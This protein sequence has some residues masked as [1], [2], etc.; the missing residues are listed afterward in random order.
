MIL[1]SQR[2]MAL[3]TGFLLST[4][5]G[6]TQSA[7][8]L[9]PSNT[10]ADTSSI[11]Q[12]DTPQTA[13]PEA[14]ANAEKQI[15]SD[16]AST[17]LTPGRY[18]YQLEDET[19]TANIRLTLASDNQIT[20]DTQATIHN[21]EA[22][23][24]TSYLQK[25][26][27]TQT[28]PQTQ[29]NITTWIEYDVQESTETWTVGADTLETER[30]TLTT[31]D[32]AVVSQGFQDESGLE[33]SDLLSDV[34]LHTQSVQFEPGASSATFSNSVIR[35]ERDVYQLGAEGGQQMTITVDALE[36]NAAFDVISPSGLI[37]EREATSADLL[38]P[39][40]GDYQVLVGGTRGN[41]SYTLTMG[42]E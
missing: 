34:T 9:P 15:T 35:G 18:C 22:G 2:A 41:A 39:H 4:L 3:V 28:A 5:V 23:Y 14:S 40:T 26:T 24:Y 12:S 42:I 38:L 1:P 29:V 6:C 30:L 31:A 11:T 32:C 20:G 36:D 37:L 16:T 19:T 7:E 21:Q 17:P 13:P 27:G 8:P 33:A 10:T 25:F